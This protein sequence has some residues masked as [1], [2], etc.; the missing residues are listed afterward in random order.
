MFYNDLTFDIAPVDVAQPDG[1]TSIAPRIDDVA[2]IELV[3]KFELGHGYAPAGGYSGIIP[4]H[5]NFGDLKTYYL[6]VAPNQWPHP[7]HAWVL[8]CDC[9]D[10]GC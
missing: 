4:Q 6:G 9:G 3:R 5:F 10:V 1:A 8:G 7:G 2:L